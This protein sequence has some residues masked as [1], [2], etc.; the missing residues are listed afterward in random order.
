MSKVIHE[1]DALEW[2]PAHH[3]L[4]SIVTSLPDADE[5]G[6]SVLEW[7]E[8]FKKAARHCMLAA[9]LDCPV[10]FYQ[11][12]RKAEGEWHSK[13]G[14][15]LEAANEVGNSLLWHKIV[16]RREPGKVDLYRPGFSHFMAFGMKCGPGKTTPDIMRVGR[17]L[18]PNG[19]GLGAA[20]QGVK[21]A[22]QHSNKLCDPFCG[23]GT[24][25]AVAD[26]YGMKAVGVDIDPAQVAASR[27][28]IV[29]RKV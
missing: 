9:S 28:L 20:I 7:R 24:V 4:G 13:A 18:Y 6:L 2:L 12:D 3:K 22:K 21:F 29:S 8:W 17:T 19:M 10:I 11:T 26:A 23:R 15:L 16:L 14:I 5:V 27:Q 1:A 25:P